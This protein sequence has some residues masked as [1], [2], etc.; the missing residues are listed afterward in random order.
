M[1]ADFAKRLR[2]GI[3]EFSSLV[4][5]A[6]AGMMCAAS[7][8]TFVML[9]VAI[10]LITITFYVLTS[11]Q[12]HRERSLEA[13]VKYLILGAAA[14]AM[15]V[16][17]IALIYGTTGSMEFTVLSQPTETYTGGQ[18]QILSLGLLMLLAGLGFKI[19]AFPFQI[20]AP[21][22][23]RIYEVEATE[24]AKEQAA[25]FELQRQSMMGAG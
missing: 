17:G 10:E 4:L 14:S 23:Y 25:K 9:F 20:W 12:Q 8:T 3:S 11:F 21:D 18:L 7:A 19:A 2:T 16:Y 22:A 6:L 1:A 24:R 15:M 13:G 5:F